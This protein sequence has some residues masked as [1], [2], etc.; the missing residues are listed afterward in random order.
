MK[1][2][3][4]SRR[5]PALYRWTPLKIEFDLT[6]SFAGV[7]QTRDQHKLIAAVRKHIQA[8]AAM[9]DAKAHIKVKTSGDD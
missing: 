5:R 9:V 3:S 4:K 7:P 1:R 6:F 2:K 8:S